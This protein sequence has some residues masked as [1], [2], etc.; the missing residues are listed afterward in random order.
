MEDTVFQRVTDILNVRYDGN[1][2]RMSKALAINTTTLAYQLNGKRSISLDTITAIANVNPDI[3]LRWLLL[4]TGNMV[5]K[6]ATIITQQSGECSQ[7]TNLHYNDTVAV[8]TLCES[9]RE[10]IKTKDE[11]IRTLLEIVS[12]CHGNV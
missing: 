2:S 9:L 7:N 8:Q 6:A 11:Q 4:G 10:Q 3:S 5:E 1:V 12:R